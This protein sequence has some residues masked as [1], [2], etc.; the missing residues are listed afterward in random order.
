M[1]AAIGRSE[2]VARFFT[3][4]LRAANVPVRVRAANGTN[5]ATDATTDARP[6][7]TP[8]AP[9]ARPRADAQTHTNGTDDVASP[10]DAANAASPGE[11][12]AGSREAGPQKAGP[13]QDHGP[14][15][16]RDPGAQLRQAIGQEEPFTG[17]FDLPLPEGEIH[18]GRMSPVVEGLDP[19]SGPRSGVP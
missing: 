14:R 4:V 9:P 2:D 8:M 13:R 3:A 1:R 12:Q 10:V 17:R 18:L 15:Q 11:R 7:H 19:G 6:G 16:P 5:G